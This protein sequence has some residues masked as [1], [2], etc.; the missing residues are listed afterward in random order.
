MALIIVGVQDRF[1][2][3]FL[4]ENV[5]IVLSE[6][7][8]FMIKIAKISGEC[9]GVNRA[10][11]LA[12]SC[13]NQ[14]GIS[15]LYKE[16]LHNPNVLKA[17]SD[18]GIE[19]IDNLDGISTDSTI[20]IRAHGEKKET[21]EYLE[22]KGYKYCDTTCLNVVKIHE[23]IED[24]YKNGYS[25]IILG[26]P[27][28][29]EVDGDLGWCNEEGIVIETI[30]DINEIKEL[31]RDVL[32]ICQTTFNEDKA[33]EFVKIIKNKFLDKN[34]EYVDTICRAQRAIQIS[35][36]KLAKESDLMIVIGGAHSSNSKELL[37]ECQEVC[38]SYKF[39]DIKVFGEWLRKQ[40]DINKSTNIGITAG[41][42]VMKRELE[43]YK[44]LIEDYLS[45]IS[46]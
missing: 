44:S 40:K 33:R 19:C 27:G 29:A 26:R 30:E 7:G 16:I 35:S 43:E 36:K 10:L 20:I 17:L 9:F 31:K 37:R 2:Y 21:Y 5:T 41:A 22:E 14:D 13:L 45:E 11:N 15:Y 12:F 3:L 6:C 1:I 8:G 18:K 32:L 38:N 34:I 42:T 39:D 28:H 25:I 4:G 23:I 46:E 24:K